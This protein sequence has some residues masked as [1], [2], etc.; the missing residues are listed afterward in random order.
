[1]RCTIM[2]SCN[3]ASNEC[4]SSRSILLI[5]PVLS[6]NDDTVVADVIAFVADDEDLGGSDATKGLITVGI[7]ESDNCYGQ[8]CM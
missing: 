1:M 3:L 8:P 6:G 2:Y 4:S 5:V 7:P